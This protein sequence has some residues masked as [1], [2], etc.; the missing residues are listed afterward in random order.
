MKAAILGYGTVGQGIVKILREE[1][2]RLEQALSTTVDIAA[3]L[4]RD[5]KKPR[6]VAC[7]PALLT[8]DVE[9]ILGDPQI[10]VIFEATSDHRAAVGYIARAL[11]AGKHVITASK[12][13]MAS[14]FAR[15]Q[16]LARENGVHLR[17]EAAVAGVIPLIASLSRELA[18]NEVDRIRGIMN[19]STNYV[20]TGLFDGRPREQVMREARAIGILEENPTDDVAG[21]DARR[22]LAI[23]GDMILGQMVGETA[24]PCIG[25]EAIDEVDVRLLQRRGYCVKLVAELRRGTKNGLPDR[26]FCASVFP[27][28]LKTDALRNCGGVQNQVLFHSSHGGEIA[29]SG[30][31]GSMEPTA[32][33]MLAD[34]CAVLRARPVYFPVAERGLYNASG[35]QK[36]VFY[37]RGAPSGRAAERVA[38]AL[39]ETWLR[40][41][42]ALVGR[43]EMTWAEAAD[44]AR[45]G[46]TVIR[47]GDGAEGGEN[48]KVSEKISAE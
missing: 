47:I 38:A 37:M 21:Y 43:G 14:D 44:L 11:R 22:K 42:D 12:A 4:V 27:T 35:E 8:T 23:L 10:Q 15:L 20:L 16:R 46:A 33:A 7:P 24:I 36:S 5:P 17:F 6:T 32:D 30:A 26:A 19:G 13:A 28:A 40:K 2:A 29:L 48:E 9:R 1:G 3:I 31:G 18:F 45:C 41:E 34:L 25:I 39:A